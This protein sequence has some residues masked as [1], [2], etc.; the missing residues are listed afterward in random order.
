MVLEEH[1][2]KFRQQIIGHDL[3]HEINDKQQKVVYADW[4]ASGRLYQP[5]EDFISHTLD[6]NPCIL[7][8]RN[9]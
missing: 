1:F 6:T 4:T 3:E 2:L 7:W 9:G 8:V 5:I